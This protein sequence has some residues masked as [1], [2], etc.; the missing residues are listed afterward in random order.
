MQESEIGSRQIR[1]SQKGAESEEKKFII[2]KAADAACERRQ[3]SFK[4]VHN[5]SL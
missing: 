5:K 1:A 2:T 3:A 4:A